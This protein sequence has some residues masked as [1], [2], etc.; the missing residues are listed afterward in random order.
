MTPHLMNNLCDSAIYSATDRVKELLCLLGQDKDRGYRNALKTIFDR[1]PT[2][3]FYE[4]DNY[5]EH[6]VNV[7]NFVVAGIDFDARLDEDKKADL[8][9]FFIQRIKHAEFKV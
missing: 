3:W 2:H 4:K 8:I 9:S 5:V 7:L 1:H 6:A